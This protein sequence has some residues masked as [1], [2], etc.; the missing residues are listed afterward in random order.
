MPVKLVCE[1]CK[2]KKD[3][4]KFMDKKYL[5]RL[6]RRHYREEKLVKC[7]FCKKESWFAGYMKMHVLEKHNGSEEKER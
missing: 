2:L 7:K 5:L 3:F 6:D 4:P 1:K